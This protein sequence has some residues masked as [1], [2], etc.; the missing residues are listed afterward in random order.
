MINAGNV[1]LILNGMETEEELIPRRH[2]T[3]H[4][5]RNFFTVEAM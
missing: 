5:F 4:R 3:T 2:R 1:Q